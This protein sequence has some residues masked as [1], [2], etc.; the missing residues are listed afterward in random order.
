MQ[1]KTLL[2]IAGLL[3][4]FIGTMPVISDKY[5]NEKEVLAL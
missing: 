2:L 4:I 3:S 1:L 5:F